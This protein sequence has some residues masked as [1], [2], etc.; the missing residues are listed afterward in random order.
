MTGADV[1]P[2]L[3]SPNAQSATRQE[4]R[5][6]R[7]VNEILTL[8]AQLVAEQGY[9]GTNLEEIADRLDLSKASIYH[10]FDAKEPLVLATLAACHS[11][12]SSQLREVAAAPGSP[13]ERLSRL[14]RRHL[15]IITAEAVETSRLFLRPVDWPPS[16]ADAVRGWQKEHGRIFRDVISEGVRA[17]EF[18]CVDERAAHM[19]IQRAMSLVPSW[20]TA[21]RSRAAREE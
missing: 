13:T 3:S 12:V 9:H 18:D 16:I 1:A 17:G 4:R 10:Y 14:I 2:W 11:Y 6:G 7:K 5:R 20:Y 15:E 21:S 19:T 8:T